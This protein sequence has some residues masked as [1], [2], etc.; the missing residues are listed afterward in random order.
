M[1]DIKQESCMILGQVLK[2]LDGH[3]D[4]VNA[5]AISTDGGKIVS[6]SGDKIVRVWSVETGQVPVIA[7]LLAVC[8]MMGFSQSVCQ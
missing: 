5:V 4:A 3:T 7:G 8:C 1:I 6:G 2:V